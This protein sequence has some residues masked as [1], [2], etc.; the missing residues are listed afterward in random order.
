MNTPLTALRFTAAWLFLSLLAKTA[1]A[2]LPIDLEVAK[3]AGVR[4]TA[5][6]QWARTLGRL[7]LGSVRIRD[8]RGGERATIEPRKLGA[9][10]RYRVVAILTARDE[11]VLPGRKF[12]SS[13][14]PSL[15]KYFQQLPAQADHASEE[16]G[17]FGLTEPQFRQIYNALSE[18][19]GFSTND[20]TAIDILRRVETKLPSPIEQ[21]QALTLGRSKLQVELKKIS[22]GTA[23]AYALRCDGL[24]LRPEQL[25]GKPLRI[26]IEP[27][28]SKRDSW[29]VGWKPPISSRRSAPQLYEKRNIEIQGFTLTQALTALAPALRMP[30]VMDQWILEQKQ[31][32]P[33]KVDVSLPKKRTFLK[34]VIGKLA[35]QGRLSTEI[36]VDELDQPFLWL[37]KFGKE[38]PQATK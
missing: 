11:L 15:A 25:P 28:N 30:V 27:Y 4:I 18:P 37:T 13:D 22:L 7:D 33:S 20:V 34:S 3:E 19:V 1:L 38:S 29:P 12:R 16:R 26:V 21:V 8:A 23:L 6:Q 14:S 31:I 5:P 9:S 32:E 24:M 35:S 17:K 36:R 2:V 10:T